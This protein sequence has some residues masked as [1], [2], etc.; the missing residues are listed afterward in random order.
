MSERF[1]ESVVEEAA[2]AWLKGLGYTVLHGPEIAWG[3][4][5]AE[6]TDPHYRDVVLEA[7]PSTRLFGSVRDGSGH[8]WPL[9]ARLEFS[10]PTGDTETV[11]TDPVTGA[12]EVE[13][14]TGTD[15]SVR[16]TAH[17]QGY[18]SKTVNLTVAEP[19]PLS[20]ALYD[21]T[22]ESST[23]RAPGW[24]GIACRKTRGCSSLA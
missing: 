17:L 12:Y 5:A 4:P 16:L 11:F 9:Y 8:E 24:A 19:T 7:R 2:L 21:F 23:C 13:I 10:V 1:T 6:R 22:M 20:A 15:Y 3:M 18:D 14:L